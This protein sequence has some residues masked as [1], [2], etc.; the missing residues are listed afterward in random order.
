MNINL[1]D[2]FALLHTLKYCSRQI[3]M[4]SPYC[5]DSSACSWDNLKTK[6]VVYIDVNIM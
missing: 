5:A 3:S 2:I 4:F 1:Y 6:Y